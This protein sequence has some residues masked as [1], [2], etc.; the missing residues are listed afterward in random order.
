VLD[1]GPGLGDFA[2]KDLTHRSGSAVRRNIYQ[3]EHRHRKDLNH[4]F[5]CMFT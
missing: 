4:R 2:S 5:R 1:A 3:I